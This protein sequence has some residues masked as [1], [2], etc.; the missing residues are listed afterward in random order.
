MAVEKND[1]ADGTKDC[2]I[3]RTQSSGLLGGRG[4]IMTAVG[5]SGLPIMFHSAANYT[6]LSGGRRRRTNRMLNNEMVV[7]GQVKVFGRPGGED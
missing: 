6:P 7:N 4:N 2:F 1:G 5:A 3:G